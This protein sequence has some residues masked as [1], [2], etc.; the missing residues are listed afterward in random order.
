MSGPLDP[1]DV[2]EGLAAQLPD[3][4]LSPE[5]AGEVAASLGASVMRETYETDRGTVYCPRMFLWLPTEEPVEEV[6]EP[7]EALGTVIDCYMTETLDSWSVEIE[8]EEVSQDRF[9]R[10]NELYAR[11][12][13]S[14]VE[15]DRLISGDGE[16]ERDL[17][18]PDRED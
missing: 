3:R 13:G 5:E 12:R 9:L 4:P 10:V 7:G 16:V 14:E 11:E 17:R 2:E 18:E 15:L 8:R 6:E 1:A